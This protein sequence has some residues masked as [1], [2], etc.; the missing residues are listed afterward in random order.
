MNAALAGL[1]LFDAGKNAFVAEKLKDVN[2]NLTFE[3]G[4]VHESVVRDAEDSP[5]PPPIRSHRKTRTTRS[6]R[7]VA[8]TAAAGAVAPS[9]AA[10]LRNSPC[11]FYVQRTHHLHIVL[12]VLL[13]CALFPE[14][15]PSH[16]PLAPLFAFPSEF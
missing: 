11:R 8:D 15:T 13:G 10:R 12:L 7:S 4:E 6:T 9:L 5:P 3:L 14:P 1:L 2:P 16:F